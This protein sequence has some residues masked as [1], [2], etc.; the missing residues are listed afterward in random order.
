MGFSNYMNDAEEVT[1]YDTKMLAVTRW[2]A[3]FSPIV[4]I[5]LTVCRGISGAVGYGAL[6]LCNPSP[7]DA[8]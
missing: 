2:R 8:S 6:I 1:D 5:L 7:L 4:G 3:L